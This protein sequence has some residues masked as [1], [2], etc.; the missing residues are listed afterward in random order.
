MLLARDERLFAA[1]ERR[2]LE[3]MVAKRL[4]SLYVGGRTRA[5]LKIVRE[6]KSDNARRNVSLTARVREMLL[7]RSLESASTYVFANDQNRP[8]W[9]SSLAKMHTRV[10]TALGFSGEF[11]LHSLRHTA[12]TRL[13]ESGCDAFTIKRLAGHS[14]ITVSERYVHPTPEGLERAFER[15]EAFNTAAKGI[16]VDNNVVTVVTQ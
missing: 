7:K 11:V 3:G 13:G 14:S 15:L 12:L 16:Q 5:W 4:D 8:F 6:G 10:R 9:N 2:H 1:L